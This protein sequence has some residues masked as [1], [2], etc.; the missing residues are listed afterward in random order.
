ML[1][2]DEF[3]NKY[4]FDI[5]IISQT[6][7]HIGASQE[8][9]SPLEVDNTVLKDSK[10]N[11]VIPGSSLKGVFRSNL[12]QILKGKDGV[13]VCDETDG[14]PC[15]DSKK[16]ENNYNNE[17]EWFSYIE[18]NIC[19]VCNLFGSNSFSSRVFF[20]DAVAE[21]S[22]QNLENRDGVKIRRDTEVGAGEAKYNYEIVSTG[23][24]F[25]TELLMENVED[26]QV[27]Y[28][29]LLIDMVNNGLIR[30]GGKK[31]AG[32]G[33]LKFDFN[34]KS[35][36]NSDI[37]NGSFEPKELDSESVKKLKNAALERLSKVGEKNV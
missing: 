30:F 36:T 37:L 28:I 32:L 15:I 11:A 18:Q 33:K 19:E 26:Y 14:N 20:S 10:G 22:K 4:F 24:E 25:K 3:K 16:R 5:K 23:T 31:S 17:S 9:L 8:G 13:Y 7:I 34:I 29:L 12:E 21:K 2:F 6:P 27:G 1:P 35:I